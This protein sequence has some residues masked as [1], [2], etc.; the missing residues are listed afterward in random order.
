MFSKLQKLSSNHGNIA[1][2]KRASARAVFSLLSKKYSP[3]FIAK[4]LESKYVKTS[5]GT[6]IFS[7]VR[8]YENAAYFKRKGYFVVYLNADK[9]TLVKRLVRERGY[10]QKE[11]L[12]E[13]E[14]ENSLYKT[15]SIGKI[16]DLTL[17]TSSKSPGE[18]AQKI[19]PLVA[20]K[21]RRCIN[22]SL[23]PNI[24]FN[25]SGYCNI[26]E[27][28][29]K[30][31]DKNHLK[32]ERRFFYSFIGKGN[33]KHDIMVGISG[34]KDS[35]AALYQI[36]KMG[37][38]PLAY[39]LD[40]GYLHPYIFQRARHVADA[41]GVD[42]EVI[43]VKKYI[44]PKIKNRFEELSMLYKRNKKEE[45]AQDYLLGREGYK[46]IVRPCWICRE[47]VIHATY[48]EA[49]KR[50]IN[51]VAIGINEWTSLKQTTSGRKFAVSAIRKLKPFR[52]KPAAYIVHFPF[53]MQKTLG[54]TRQVLKKMGWHYYNNVQSN[55]ASCLLACAAEK[56]LY[57]NLGFHPD[58]TR[59]AREVTVGFL[60]K[61]EA[62]KALMEARKCRFSIPQ[63]L[64][65]AK[66]A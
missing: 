25:K 13:L 20:T 32:K 10:S 66:L 24:T 26:C 62:K 31:F 5:S 28:Y 53:L 34:G 36:K 30:Y 35:S 23:N 52:N 56:Q 4:S 19:L 6:L 37:F 46:G 18:I 33:G 7:G 22:T 57:A 48:A 49:V 38:T 42:Y 3:D 59:L 55:A 50:G 17:N 11:A 60:T 15:R 44:T 39:T 61:K 29:M 43:P 16:A 9:K 51:L 63:V 21:C 45:F 1:K 41:C 65:K 14:S 12:N 54:S 40:L 64:K 58:T 2:N 27:S 47:L 8:E